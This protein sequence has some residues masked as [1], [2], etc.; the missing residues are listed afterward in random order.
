MNNSAPATH[1]HGLYLQLFPL[2]QSL[3]DP[4]HRRHSGSAFQPL[5]AAPKVRKNR[6]ECSVTAIEV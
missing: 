2:R 4:S 3:P 6:F 5:L 1:I